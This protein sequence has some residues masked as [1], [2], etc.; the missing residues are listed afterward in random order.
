MFEQP[1][2]LTISTAQGYPPVLACA[3]LTQ[4]GGHRWV[5][6]VRSTRR[7]ELR[8]HACKNFQSQVFFVAQSVCATLDD[9]DLI[10]QTFNES[11]RDLV[12]GLAVGSDSIPMPIDHLSEFLVGFEALPLQ[13]R[14]PV[15][16]EAACPPLALVVP[17][18]T[19]GLPE[20]IRRIQA[21]V[22][23]QQRLERLPALPA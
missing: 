19:E 15:L 11:E 18:L 3:P 20:Q 23:R 10:V 13:A 6:R 16:E 8:Q 12:L 21:F 1:T 2:C 4:A 9:A 22:C 17:E 7:L 14:T 5:T